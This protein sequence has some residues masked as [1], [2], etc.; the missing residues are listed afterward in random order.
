MRKMRRTKMQNKINETIKTN[1]KKVWI[2]DPCYVIQDELWDDVEL[3]SKSYGLLEYEGKGVLE[4]LIRGGDLSL[5]G[6]A[7]S[8][9]RY[10]QDVQSY[11]RSTELEMTAWEMLNMSRNEWTKL[12]AA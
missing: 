4:H 12:N 7:N 2:G 6:L 3:A 1:T 9:T 11:D 5:Y 10:A 8:V